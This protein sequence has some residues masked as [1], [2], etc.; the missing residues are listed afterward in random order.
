MLDAPTDAQYA[1]LRARDARHDGW[2]IVAVTSTGIYCRPSCPARTPR[3]EHIRIAPTPAAAQGAGFRACMRCR[4]DASPGS[5]DWDARGDIAGRAMRLIADGTIDRDGVP[6]LAR[7]LGYSERQL[8]RILTAEL[9][10]GPIALARAHRAQ[11]ARILIE[12]TD[13]PMGRVAL[14]AGFASLRQFNDTV[15]DIFARTP[16]ELRARRR[17]RAATEAGQLTLRLPFRAPL[18]HAALWRF[19]HAR[20][21]PGVERPEP[22]GL[23]R[24]MR[25]PRGQARAALHFPAGAEAVTCHLHLEDVRDLSAAVSRCRALLDL[26]ADPQAIDAALGHDPRLAPS[27]SA[28]PGRRVPGAVDG[29]ELAVRAIL[30][31]QVSVAAA[32]T[33]AARVAERHGEPCRIAA[34]P[35]APE[36]T[37]CFPAP[38]ALADAD[39]RAVGL[40]ASRAATIRQLAALVAEGDL[41]LAPGADRE[42]AARTLLAI[43]G[44]GPWTVDY[45]LARALRDPDRFPAADL[46]VRQRLGSAGTPLSARAANERAEAWRPWRSYA[47]MHVW[48]PSDPAVHSAT[49]PVREAA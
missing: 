19:L 6:G 27:V 20:A 49:V 24:T 17:D 28:G 44:I 43:R 35:G 47:L 32:R 48:E 33:L 2:F 14:A 22:D 40:P 15:R 38:E 42:Q 41:Q 30:G 21:L 31:Q 45:V 3:R 11:T 7:Q 26:D 29:F 46:V 36:P 1:A 13:L 25:L 12:T 37:Q 18:D 23:T 16:S 39:L 9:G 10:A 8:H 34:T 4:P 5:P